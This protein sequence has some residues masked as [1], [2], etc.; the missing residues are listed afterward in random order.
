[1]SVCDCT[2]DRMCQSHYRKA[3]SSSRHAVIIE[4]CRGRGFYDMILVATL[5][6]D[7]F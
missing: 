5:N 2:T 4:V 3:A 6:F 1:M 7:D